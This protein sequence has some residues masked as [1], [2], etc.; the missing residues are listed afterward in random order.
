MDLIVIYRTFHPN[1]KS[2]TL[3]A[4]QDTFLKWTTFTEY[5]QEKENRNNCILSDKNRLN[6][7]NNNK[8]RKPTYLWKLNNSLL[9]EK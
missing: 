4:S 7:D 5:Q 9:S 2:Y 8:H 6:L 1:T 3:L